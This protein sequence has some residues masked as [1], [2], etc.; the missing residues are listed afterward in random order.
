MAVT[1]LHYGG[2]E[3]QLDEEQV[4]VF[5]VQVRKAFESENA[6]E[7]VDAPLAVGGSVSVAVSESIP[8]AIER[9]G[10]GSSPTAMF[11]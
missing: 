9:K 11:V 3:F 4:P 10:K 1:K 5:I 2:Q 8:I 6:I 7:F